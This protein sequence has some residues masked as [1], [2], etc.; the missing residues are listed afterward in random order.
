MKRIAC[1][2]WTD[3]DGKSP[4][5]GCE[6]QIVER[7]GQFSPIVGF[8]PA[9]RGNV[10]LDFTGLAHLFGGEAVMAE[11][12]VRDLAQFGYAVRAAVA[13][14]IGAAWA[15][16]HYCGREIPL[17]PTLRVGTL[18]SRRSASTGATRSVGTTGFPRGAWEPE[19]L[20]FQIFNLQSSAFLLPLPIEAL[21]LPAEIVRVLHELGLVRIGQLET[22]PREEFLS[23]F[24]PVLLQ[25][26]D[27]AF[28]RLDEPVP[29][30]PVPPKFEAGWAAEHPSA[31]RETVAAAVEWLIARVAAMLTRCGRGALRLDCRLFLEI[32]NPRCAEGD[33]PIFVDHGFA[34][35]PAKIGTVPHLSLSIGLFQPTADAKRLFELIQL[36]LERLRISS[37]VT[38]VEVAASLSALLE[39]RKQETLFDLDGDLRGTGCVAA[40][41]ERLSSRLGSRAV[42]GVRLRPEAQPELA[43]HYDPLVG[44]RRRNR[45]GISHWVGRSTSSVP[46]LRKSS[47]ASGLASGTACKQA[48]AHDELPPR[49][50]RLLPRPL[51]A[52]VTS[53]APDGPPLRFQLDGCE[54][55]A[56]IF[57]SAK[58]G[59][60]SSAMHCEHTV[61]QSWGPERIETGWWRGRAVGRDYFRV[62]ILSGARFWL[63]RRLRDGK[64]FLH[65][66]FE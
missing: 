54:G 26:L 22:L 17:V 8:D 35:V 48:V 60:S 1:I 44:G 64:W 20:K 38:A 9:D 57:V 19:K 66:V 11:A 24:G 14:T 34:A 33:S 55:T 6:L 13:D 40:L 23:R 42:V 62:E 28:G 39:P 12:I 21:R 37:P 27:Q 53:I 52:A 56:P 46:L 4:L 18:G 10:F 59:L 61:V 16:V 30:C 36:Q 29:A 51:P 7:C 31:R 41:V 45:G 58:M 50:L 25:R 65:G 43:W 2:H 49:P 3:A 32:N 63:F 15:A 5:E 47:A